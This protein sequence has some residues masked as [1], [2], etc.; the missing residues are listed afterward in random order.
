MLE[1]IIL[2]AIQGVTEWIPVSSKACVIGAKIHFF[3]SQASLN[4]LINYALFLHLGTFLAAVVYFRRDIMHV[5]QACS[6][7]ASPG[8]EGR[9][10][11][12]FLFLVT[13]FTSLG[14]LL[15]NG[16][17]DIAHRAPHAKTAITCIIAALL[18]VAGFLQLKAS[19][20]GK[21]SAGNLTVLD[22]VLLGLVQALACLPGLS[23][24]GTTMAALSFRG[25]AKE[26]TLKLSFLMSLP[27]IF[28][29]N[30]VKNHHLLLTAGSA[31]I[32]VLTA[33][34]VGLLSIN[35]LMAFAKKVNFGGFLIFIGSILAI[36]TITGAID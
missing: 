4:E 18:I 5:L 25:F 34:G 8:S 15:V 27:V 23:R 26:E 36:A 11:L 22:G 24:A 3:N 21:R 10:I 9:R 29:G 28:I 20:T 7:K 1:H 35:A 6:P 19:N 16:V 30:I 14:Q 12:V 32:G 33:F 13:L 31:W 2:G 17:S